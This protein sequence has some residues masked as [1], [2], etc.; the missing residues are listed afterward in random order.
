[1][2]FWKSLFGISDPVEAPVLREPSAR[3][4]GRAAFHVRRFQRALD[5]CDENR[6]ERRAQ[7]TAYLNYYTALA[8]A[9]ALKP[10]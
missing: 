5:Q 2:S 8:D 7:L 4:R 6:T 3:E 9:A 10:E 1:M